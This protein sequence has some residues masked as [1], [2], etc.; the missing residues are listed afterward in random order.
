MT[1]TFELA[2]IVFS[3][4]KPCPVCGAGMTHQPDHAE[5]CMETRL[6]LRSDGRYA[7]MVDAGLIEEA[8][9]DAGMTRRELANALGCTPQSLRGW[10]L[11]GGVA[12]PAI[13]QRLIAVFGDKVRL[14]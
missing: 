10:R 13:A 8:R 14:R 11:G 7:T 6:W 3:L 4:E 2:P 12:D 1:A 9:V 5:W